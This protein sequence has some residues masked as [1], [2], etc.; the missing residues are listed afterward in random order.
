[1]EAEDRLNAVLDA[2]E[3]MPVPREESTF[4]DWARELRELVDD[5]RS[6]ARKTPEA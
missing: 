2:I 6:A 3:K 4:G 1:M 5:V